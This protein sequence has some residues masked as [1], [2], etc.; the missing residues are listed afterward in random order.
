VASTTALTARSSAAGDADAGFLQGGRV[1]ADCSGGRSGIPHTDPDITE[2]AWHKLFP[3]HVHEDSQHGGAEAACP[4]FTGDLRADFL[5]SPVIDSTA[6]ETFHHHQLS[7]RLRDR[8]LRYGGEIK[9]RSSRCLIPAAAQ[10]C[11][12]CIVR[13]RGAEGDVRCFFALGT[14]DDAI[15]RPKRS[16]MATTSTLDRAACHFEMVFAK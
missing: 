12:P 10:T 8:R 3:Q 9:R 15:G 16:L 2:K 7:Q 4:Q 5:A 1:R 6:H 14:Q 11:Y 13:Q